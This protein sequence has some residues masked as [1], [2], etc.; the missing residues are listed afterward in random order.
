MITVNINRSAN[1]II[2]NV[3]ITISID[4]SSGVYGPKMVS[5]TTGCGLNVFINGTKKNN[6]PSE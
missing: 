4:I 5:M 6:T 2:Q 1:I 3:N